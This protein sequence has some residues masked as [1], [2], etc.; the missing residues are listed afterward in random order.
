MTQEI[1]YPG[2]LSL[3]LCYLD[4]AAKTVTQYQTLFEKFARV[5]EA[6]YAVGKGVRQD[7]LKA[8]VE[9]CRRSGIML[10]RA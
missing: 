9:I 4:K 3:K 10:C 5:A 6:T 2:K 1:A 7:V 8:Q